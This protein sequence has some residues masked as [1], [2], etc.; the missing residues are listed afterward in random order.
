M[1]IARAANLFEGGIGFKGFQEVKLSTTFKGFQEVKVAKT[2]KGFQEVKLSKAHQPN[3]TIKKEMFL[4]SVTLH[5]YMIIIIQ[6]FGYTVKPRYKE[7]GY[8]KT[9]FITRSFCWS[10]VFIFVCFFTLI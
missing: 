4:L 3:D 1:L 2:F 8:N 9:L 7:V 10:Q 5:G 6:S